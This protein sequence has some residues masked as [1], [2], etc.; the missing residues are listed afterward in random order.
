MTASIDVAKAHKLDSTIQHDI[1]R[2]I[3][4]MIDKVSD[5]GLGEVKVKV[6][7]A[8]LYDNFDGED[9]ETFTE[10]EVQ[11]EETKQVEESKTI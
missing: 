10:M 4:L 9:E 2:L 3:E 7:V 8:D 6:D 1:F 5:D 11:P